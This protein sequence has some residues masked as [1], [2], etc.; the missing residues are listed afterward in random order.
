MIRQRYEVNCFAFLI[1]SAVQ[2][3]CRP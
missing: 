2:Q 1:L 3:S